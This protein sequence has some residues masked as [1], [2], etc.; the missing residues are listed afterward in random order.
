VESG[1]TFTPIRGAM[2]A[3]ATASNS[4]IQTATSVIFTLR[5]EHNI[6]K[7]DSIEL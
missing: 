1:I 4:V 5:P 3:S 2:T 7:D 6:F